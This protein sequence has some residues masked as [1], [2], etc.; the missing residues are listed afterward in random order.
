MVA[1]KLV[2]TRRHSRL[3]YRMGACRALMGS[4]K[5]QPTLNEKLKQ[6]Y[7]VI[8]DAEKKFSTK[9]LSMIEVSPE[10]L[11]K[12]AVFDFQAASYSVPENIGTLAIAITRTGK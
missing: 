3:W 8:N 11:H 2:Q 12:K 10:L 9:K 5:I 7:D 4:P 6:V 1:Y